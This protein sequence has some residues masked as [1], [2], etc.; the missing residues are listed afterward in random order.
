M[1]KYCIKVTFDVIILSEDLDESLSQ[2][3]IEG[4][5]IEDS[6]IVNYVIEDVK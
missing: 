2:I 3:T 4:A 5:E 1:K 6:S